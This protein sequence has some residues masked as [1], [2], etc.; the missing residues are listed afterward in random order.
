VQVLIPIQP[1]AFA[2]TRSKLSGIH[3]SYVGQSACA[4]KLKKLREIER[5]DG[6][7]LQLKKVILAMI[8]IDAID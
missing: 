1:C 6:S 7:E 3:C 8:H 4:K 2:K 5:F